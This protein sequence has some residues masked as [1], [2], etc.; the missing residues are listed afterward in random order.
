[1]FRYFAIQLTKNVFCMPVLNTF[2][3]SSI[4]VNHV[5]LT[6]NTV[7]VCIGTSSITNRRYNSVYM[8]VK[9]D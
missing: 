2:Q 8:Y 3:S 9:N 4:K 7:Y 6:F 1:M 5:K